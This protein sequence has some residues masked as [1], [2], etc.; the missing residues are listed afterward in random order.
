MEIGVA[1]QYPKGLYVGSVYVVL[2]FLAVSAAILASRKG[3]YFSLG[4]HYILQTY[5][6]GMVVAAVAIV[7]YMAIHH[8][9]MLTSND[10]SHL[11][12]INRP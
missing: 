12:S 9:D 2:L 5:L 11:D 8:F 6:I 3:G 4:R 1:C 7:A 10:K